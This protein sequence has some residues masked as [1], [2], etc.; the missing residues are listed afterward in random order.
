MLAAFLP[1]VIVAQKPAD[2]DRGIFAKYRVTSTFHGLPAKPNL[3]DP[4]AR[5]YRT[6]LRSAAA[7]GPT[8]AGRYSVALWGCG[9]GCIAF[10]VIDA[11]SGH[12][13]F[14]PGTISGMFNN[15]QRLTYKLNSRAV[16]IV[17][18]INEADSA[19]RWYLW[20]GNRFRLISESPLDHR[21]ASSPDSPILR[22]SSMLKY[23]PE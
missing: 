23:N 8:F 14:F 7:E 21:L 19:D 22:A 18:S 17:G 9:T 12:V 20:T 11:T 10:A 4:G 16:H 5:A 13:T 6:R 2:A 15:G 3:N 1:A